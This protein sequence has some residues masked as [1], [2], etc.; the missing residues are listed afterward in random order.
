[1][2]IMAVDCG[3]NFDYLFRVVQPRFKAPNISC[4]CDV[5]RTTLLPPFKGNSFKGKSPSK[6]NESV[7][8]SH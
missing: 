7:F 2:T 8:L 6:Q 4:M 3:V 1:M 5:S